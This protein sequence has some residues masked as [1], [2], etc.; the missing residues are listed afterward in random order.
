MAC[1]FP[2]VRDSLAQFKIWT[3][4]VLE[5]IVG[6]EENEFCMLMYLEL[7]HDFPSLLWNTEIVISSSSD[8]FMMMYCVHTVCPFACQMVI[9]CVALDSGIA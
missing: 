8:N 2:K 7:T 6:G 9:T 5:H 1:W 3:L 4:D